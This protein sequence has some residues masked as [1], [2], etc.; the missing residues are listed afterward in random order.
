M[1]VCSFC[2][3]S[4]I[5]T[6]IPV[7]YRSDNDIFMHVCMHA[8]YLAFWEKKIAMNKFYIALYELKSTIVKFNTSWKRK[9]WNYFW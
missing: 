5:C 2:V 1:Y 9:L 8:L 3:V 4:N 7:D 6:C